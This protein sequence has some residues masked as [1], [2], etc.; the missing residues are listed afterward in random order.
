M[1]SEAMPLLSTDVY[2]KAPSALHNVNTLPSS[3]P[4]PLKSGKALGEK[5]EKFNIR[6]RQAIGLSA[7]KSTGAAFMFKGITTG[8]KA[9]QGTIFH[10]TPSSQPNYL[11]NMRHLSLSF[12]PF[13]IP[14]WLYLGHMLTS[15]LIS[16]SKGMEY[17]INQTKESG[18][19]HKEGC[20]RKTLWALHS[21]SSYSS[22]HHLCRPRQN[23][24]VPVS[25]A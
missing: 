17:W 5:E 6:E 18:L 16:E 2:S 14:D 7:G 10:R 22:L 8:T 19:L 11:S 15:A 9:I 23:Y 25:L 21:S 20:G 1:L 24:S 13:S 12:C 4:E 3:S